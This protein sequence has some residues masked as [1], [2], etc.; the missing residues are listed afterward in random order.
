MNA[1]YKASYDEIAASLPEVGDHRPLSSPAGR[2]T[3]RTLWL[4]LLALTALPFSYQL[5]YGILED[6][7]VFAPMPPL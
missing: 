6:A 4:S 7:T 1:R 3:P 5:R 2:G